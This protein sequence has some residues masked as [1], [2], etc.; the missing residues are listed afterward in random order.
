MFQIK[1]ENLEKEPLRST[2]IS[3]A[4]DVQHCTTSV[5]EGG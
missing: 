1:M 4:P 2:T 5:F 3:L